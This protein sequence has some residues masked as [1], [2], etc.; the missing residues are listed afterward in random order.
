MAL[1]SFKVPG[2]TPPKTAAK[3]AVSLWDGLDGGGSNSTPQPAV[4]EYRLRYISGE[5]R[6]ESPKTGHATTHFI[7]EVVELDE[8]GAQSHAVGDQVDVFFIVNGKSR[9]VGMNRVFSLMTACAGFDSVEE[10][11]AFDPQGECYLASV[12][13]S[14]S[15]SAD[16]RTVH[17]RL[18]DVRVT[19]GGTTANG[20][21]YRE[22]QWAP[23]PDEEQGE[24]S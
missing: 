1:K 10:Y 20:D 16:G 23:V 3:K 8:R 9:I 21:Y 5:A 12:G 7:F 24:Q 17:G 11:R 6:G 15:Y 19:K 13:E 4:G 18:V 22:Y 14:N 2:A